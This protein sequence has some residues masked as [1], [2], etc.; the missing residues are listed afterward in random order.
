MALRIKDVTD[1]LDSIAPRAYQESY[2]NS[3]LLTGSTDHLLT[4]ILVTLDCTEA[5]LEEAIAKKANLVI[6]HHPIIFRGLKKITG[7][8]YVE[9]TVI[10]AIKNDI[11]IFAIH[12][13]LDNVHTGVNR[14]ISEKIGLINL[15]I[16]EPKPS[17]LSKLVTF[18]PVD[19]TEEVL[20][21]LHGAGAGQ[22]GNYE[23]CSF[24]M[25]GTGSFRPSAAAN[26]HIGE[27]GKQEE[28]RENRVEL[29]FPAHLERRIITAL[30]QSHPYEEVAYYVS[31]L[32]N[33]NQEVGSG[34]IGELE[35]PLE[36][37][38]FLERLKKCMDLRVVR[39][40]QLIDRPVRKVAVCGGSGSFLLSKAVSA[41]ADAFVSADF[42]YHEFFDAENRIIIADI[43]HYESEVYTKELLKEVL[44]K[45]FPTF[46]INFS[47]TVTNPISYF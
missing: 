38:K 31:S 37:L 18:I 7:S 9:R 27:A 43:G 29:I 34:M 39:H 32:Q 21:H 15:S 46:A 14:K 17:T 23:N 11:S 16:L 22:I 28:V 25:E 42:K 12:T 41:G 3:G 33:D 36:P 4:G 19:D 44:I 40:T 30:R 10:K 26:P 47:E 2:D 6:A 5:V 45:K 35:Q 8:N 1:Y 24:R 13:N 20:R